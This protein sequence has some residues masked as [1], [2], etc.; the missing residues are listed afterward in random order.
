AVKSR[1]PA[2]CLAPLTVAARDT[3]AA[4]V[5]ARGPRRQFGRRHPA[6]RTVDAAGWND[7]RPIDLR[8][9]VVRGDR[10]E[11]RRLWTLDLHRGRSLGVRAARQQR[12]RLQYPKDLAGESVAHDTLRR[13]APETSFFASDAGSTGLEELEGYDGCD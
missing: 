4:A 10:R 12:G 3:V 8:N 9:D 7:F 2:F 1:E 5:I 6:R 13:L 11:Q